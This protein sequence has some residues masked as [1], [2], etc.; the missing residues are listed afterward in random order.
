MRANRLLSL[1]LGVILAAGCNQNAAPQPVEL[2]VSRTPDRASNQEM[3]ERP[4]V[5]R[6]DLKAIEGVNIVEATTAPTTEATTMPLAA[7][8]SATRESD[9]QITAVQTPSAAAP[10]KP[11]A[12][13]Q[14]EELPPTAATG[15]F[16]TEQYRLVNQ[17]NE[18][19]S[20]LKNGMVVI[21][22][23]VPTPVVAVRGY[24]LT[25]GVYEGQ[26][27]GG[28]LS[29]LL[30]H[31]VAG[32]SSQRRNEAQ[33][34]DLL[35]RIGND[36]NA[37]TSEDHT[38]YFINTTA[39]HMTEAV[40]LV[41]GWML[42]ATI[43]PDEYRREYEVVQREL[44]KDKGEPGWVFYELAQANRYRVSPA[45]VPVIGYQEVIQGL[46][47]DDVYGYYK[48]TYVPNNMV[49]SLTGDLEPEKMLSA[50]QKYV[51]E[52]GN[53]RVPSRDIQDEPPVLSP[54]TVVATFPKLGQAKLQ[55]GFPSVSMQSADL[56]AL[57]LLATIL[58]GGESSLM[59][60]ELRDKR[61]LVNTVVVVNPTP[62]FV[63]GTFQIEMELA[64]EKIAEAT[65]AA[66]AILDQVMREGLSD[67]RIKRGKVQMRTARV[68]SLQTSESTAS[69]LATD[70][71][72]TGDPHFTDRYVKRVEE[73]AAEQLKAIANKYFV[74]QRLLTTALLP[75][76]FVGAGGLPK[77]EDLIRPVAPTTKETAAAEETP[78]VTRVELPN[79]AILLHKRIATLPLVEIKMFSLG[80]VTAEDAKTNGL[81]N[82]AME[83]LPRGTK[84]RTAQQIAEFFD[85]I[86]GDLD[87]SCG[88]NSWTWSAT[89]LKGDLDKTMEV[90]G[91]VVNDP[92][93]PDAELAPMKTRIA[94]TIE[95]QDADWH[96]Q[97]MRFFKSAYFGQ[98]NSPYQ[99]MPI[100]T[101]ENVAGFTREQVRDW[102]KTQV[103][104]NR[105]VIAIY[106]DVDLDHAKAL[107]SER[108]GVG[109]P[110]Q[111]AKAPAAGSTP[112]VQKARAGKPG[113]E[114]LRVEMQ[115]T[116]QPLAG[117]IIGYESDSVVGDPANYPIAVGDTMCSGFTYP[118]GYLHEI[119]RGRG[120]VY[121][122]H[123][124]NW[125]GR[126]KELPG[127]FFV[128]AG[129]DPGKVNEVVDVILENIAR[130]QGSEQDTQPGW[131]ERSKQLITTSD[132]MANE[133]P[134]EQA[135]TAAL[136]ELNGLGYNYH[137]Q[138]PRR[139]NQVNLDDVRAIASERLIKCVVTICTPA[140]EAVKVEKGERTYDSFPPVDLTP[141]GVQHDSK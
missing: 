73:V 83:M 14:P 97:A 7:S 79:G 68:K 121:V 122:V 74:K 108:L 75:A 139:I 96:Q 53:G 66:M 84:T 120:L 40:D 80:G 90:L 15:G 109:D 34:R 137:D 48:K 70:F 107:A 27:L 134:A 1:G 4:M 46:S 132:A 124:V 24:V 61:R 111:N 43:T 20:V 9:E 67:D 128:Y 129:C 77:A 105:R 119:L 71:I 39:E 29:H 92:A 21:A 85:S 91:D 114:V 72:N 35:Q 22:K 58:G 69:S 54:R 103:M 13:S 36:S 106:G 23:R 2:P 17:S 55:L 33:N 133:T 31:L 81:G 38:A 89:C 12:T 3:V 52:V 8:R 93:F 131:F 11:Q 102:Y 123:A 113:V 112:M 42:G 86:G 94:A 63:D 44:E 100:G 130:L 141:R 60:E 126:S 138:F 98:R 10:A 87:T 28:G 104:Q 5:R 127:N 59:V 62:A 37:Y 64:P 56:Y 95:S 26:W 57:D 78:K 82:L 116:Q 51:G 50:V 117:V 18:I 88:N 135:M 99:F 76:E 25:G 19:V 30:E 45:R 32:G 125:P 6:G 49:F 41:T 16:A 136:D 110:I 140:P 115:K 47:R 101:K 118:T 65:D